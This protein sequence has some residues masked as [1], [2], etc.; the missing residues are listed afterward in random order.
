MGNRGLRR[1][2]LIYLCVL[3]LSGALHVLTFHKDLFEC[4]AQW[5]CGAMLLLWALSIRTRV[6]DR[7]QLPDRAGRR[8]RAQRTHDPGDRIRRVASRARS[9][10]AP[11][12][13]RAG[14]Q[15]FGGAGSANTPQGRI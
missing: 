5:F 4:F 7:P 3:L 12:D 13:E 10:A 15:C 6:T 9:T 8:R 1:S 14:P 11:P 2:I